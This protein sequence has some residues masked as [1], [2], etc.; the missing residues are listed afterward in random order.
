MSWRSSPAIRCGPRTSASAPTPRAIRSST[1]RWSLL[2]ISTKVGVGASLRFLRKQHGILSLLKRPGREA[3]TL[4]DALAPLVGDRSLG[5]AGLHLF[6][7]N[8]LVA[9]WEWSQELPPAD[10]SVA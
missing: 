3:D 1:R 9:T 5:L 7:F 4:R 10:A 6:T 2:E 8:E